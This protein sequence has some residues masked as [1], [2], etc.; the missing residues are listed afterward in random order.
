MS[1]F[2]KFCR[3]EFGSGEAWQSR[4]VWAGQAG[5]WSGAASKAGSVETW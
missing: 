4:Q 5:F 1:G 3:G 2:V